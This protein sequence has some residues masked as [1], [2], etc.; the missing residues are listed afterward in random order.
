MLS[1]RTRRQNRPLLLLLKK[2]QRQ[3]KMRH[4]QVLKDRT[5]HPHK[6]AKIWRQFRQKIQ[7]MA[8]RQQRIIPKIKT[9]DRKMICRKMPPIQIVRHRI[10][11]LH[12]ICQPEIWETKHRMPG[13]RHNR[14]TNRI[15]QMRRTECRGTIRR[16]AGKMPAIRLPPNPQIKQG[17]TNPPVLQIPLPRQTLHLRMAAAI[18]EGLIWLMASSLTAVRK[19]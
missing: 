18:L 4:R 13:N 1:R 6:A 9:R 16:Q 5:C 15:W 14:Q 8:V 19:M 10:T 2:R 3:K 11:P 17:T 12:R 7:A